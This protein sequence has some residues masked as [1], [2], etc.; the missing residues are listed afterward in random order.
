MCVYSCKYMC[1]Y[2]H[3]KIL[4]LYK[5]VEFLLKRKHLLFFLRVV[6]EIFFFYAGNRRLK[7]EE[8]NNSK[9]LLHWCGASHFGASVIRMLHKKLSPRW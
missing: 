2:I 3:F 7:Y 1:M 6:D 4:K 5:G 8:F 9:R